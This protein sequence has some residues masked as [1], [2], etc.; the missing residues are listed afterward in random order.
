LLRFASCRS[1]HFTVAICPKCATTSSKNRSNFEPQF[2]RQLD[3]CWKGYVC[4]QLEKKEIKKITNKFHFFS[5][6]SFLLNAIRQLLH[7]NKSKRLGSTN[8]VIELKSHEFFRPIEWDEL[9]A[10][11]IKPPFNPN[12][13]SIADGLLPRSSLSAAVALRR[14]S[15]SLDC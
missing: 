6:I 9:E 8:D 2:H 3:D 11:R 7:K 1:R 5:S 10:R 15:T 13:V 14:R 12:V 4:S